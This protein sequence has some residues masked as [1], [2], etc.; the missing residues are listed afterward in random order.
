MII[1][2]NL[3][4]PG[5][6]CLA[7]DTSAF[8]FPIVWEFTYCVSDSDEG[9]CSYTELNSADKVKSA[10]TSGSRVVGSMQCHPRGLGEWL[11]PSF[12]LYRMSSCASLSPPCRPR[13]RDLCIADISSLS[14]CYRLANYST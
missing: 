2:N 12:M 11:P 4:N 9:S 13:D 3:N 14:I 8:S 5:P 10:C 1:K 7:P 6:T